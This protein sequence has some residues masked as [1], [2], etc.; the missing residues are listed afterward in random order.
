[1]HTYIRNGVH[2]R[3]LNG[4][5]LYTVHC[6]C[7]S[8]LWDNP[9]F[10]LNYHF[11]VVVGRIGGTIMKK[12]RRAC[13]LCRYSSTP[14]S[15]PSLSMTEKRWCMLS[16]HFLYTTHSCS[17]RWVQNTPRKYERQTK[18][19]FFLGGRKTCFKLNGS[20]AGSPFTYFPCLS[21]G[22]SWHNTITWYWK[23]I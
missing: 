7:S 19:V 3:T 11:L 16:F 18:E 8:P 9:S 10:G 5:T 1:M 23:T 6:S 12:K 15:S 14:N 2:R 20:G 21:Y 22:W 17:S 13:M 4:F